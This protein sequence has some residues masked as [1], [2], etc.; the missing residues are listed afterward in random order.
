MTTKVV[1][2]SQAFSGQPETLSW[3]VANQGAGATNASQWEDDVYMSASQSLDTSAI[4]L[5]KFNHQSTLQPGGGYTDT[6]TVTLPVGVSGP[7]YF[8]VQSDGG[9]SNFEAGARAN[10]VQSTAAATDVHLTPPPDLEVSVRRRR[11][12]WPATFSR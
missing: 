3:T 2:P 12:P 8:I 7:F 4:L 5:G 9:G 11:R 6:E 10:N 1:A